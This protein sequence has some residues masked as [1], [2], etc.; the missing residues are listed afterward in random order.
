METQTLNAEVRQVTGRQVKHLREQ[1]LVPAVLYGRDLEAVSLQVETRA[2]SKV[3]ATAGTYQLISLEV[4]G[5][6]PR[7]ILARAVQRDV[8]RR[9][10]LHVDFYAVKMDEKVTA[11]VPLIIEGVAPAVRDKGGVLTQGL[12]HLEIECLPA[13]LISAILVNIEGLENH[14]DTIIVSDLQVSGSVTILS[15]LESMVVKIEPP[16]K[17][18]AIEDQEM[19]ER[20]QPDVITEATDKGE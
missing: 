6:K 11:Q 7:M 2:L 10:Y 4:N 1:G 18:E 9:E 5:Q 14:N 13:D 16:R 3:L 12:D 8:I 20:A 19:G 15:D 17:A